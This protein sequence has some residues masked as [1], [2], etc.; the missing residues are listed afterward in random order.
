MAS[1]ND[2]V[3][4]T[5]RANRGEAGGPWTG[6]TMILLHSV[7]RHSGDE[8]VNPLVAAPDGDAYVICGTY[9]GAPVD[10]QWVR[11]LEA[12]DGTATIELGGETV[13]AVYRVVRAG[14]EDWERLYG[15]WREYWPGV[16]EYE[17]RTDRKFPVVLLTVPA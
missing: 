5:F 17:K 16:A 11:N 10:P 3:I 15:I 2:R 12:G 13:E 6:K 7:G 14:D 8:H 4:E 9:G 1:W